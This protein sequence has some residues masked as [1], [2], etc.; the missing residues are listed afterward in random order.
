MTARNEWWCNCRRPHS[1]SLP[2]ITPRRPRDIFHEEG[3]EVEIRPGGMG[4]RPVAE[5][6]GGAAQYGV[7]ASALIVA[8]LRG[9]PVVLVA[10]IFQHSSLALAVLRQSGISMPADLQGKRV[11][12][13]P[14]GSTPEIQAMLVAGGMAP[15][16]YTPVP[17]QWGVDEIETGAAE[18]MVV[19]T[20][21][22]SRTSSRGA[23]MCS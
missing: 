23:L 9:A 6:T 10:A 2:V 19:N 18:A 14:H 11:A 13:D 15:V 8:R 22:P 12:L 16:Q 7:E 3:L 21:R 5:V 17:D 20:G 4:I 1:S